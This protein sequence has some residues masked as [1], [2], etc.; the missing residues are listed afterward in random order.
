MDTKLPCSRGLVFIV[1]VHVQV[2][3]VT[4]QIQ[5]IAELGKVAKN[6]CT[7]GSGVTKGI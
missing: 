4:R 6:T 5:R 2:K 7:W 3:T 1:V